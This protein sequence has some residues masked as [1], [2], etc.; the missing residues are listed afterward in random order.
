[1]R[2]YWLRILLGA[3]AVFAIGMLGVTMVRRGRNKVEAV[4]AGAGPL[5]IPTPFVPFQ[6]AATS[7]VRSTTSWSTARPPRRC[8]RSSFR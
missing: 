6:L 8:P 1:M 3:F 5:T 4:F 2:S 7:S